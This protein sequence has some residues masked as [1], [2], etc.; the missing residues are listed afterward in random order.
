MAKFHINNAGEAGACSATKG[1][2]PFG[3]E[4]DHFTSAAAARAS[5]E[6]TM[7]P[8]ALSIVRLP[9]KDR[10][11][12]VPSSAFQLDSNAYEEVLKTAETLKAADRFVV[13]VSTFLDRSQKTED[14]ERPKW[15]DKIYGYGAYASDAEGQAQ[16]YD[17]VREWEESHPL[18]QTV[19]DFSSSAAGTV[20]HSIAQYRDEEH[21]KQELANEEIPDAY[22]LP[23]GEGI[24]DQENSSNG[25]Y[26]TRPTARKE[27]GLPT[28]VELRVV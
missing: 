19:D 26:A 5:Y 23:A 1:N 27:S 6:Q 7:A 24:L 4:D 8:Q 2:C 18:L 16:Y 21:F 17:D 10:P 13:I 11:F 9:A 22:W 14:E 15:D 28:Y 12:R 20:R 25:F 3:D